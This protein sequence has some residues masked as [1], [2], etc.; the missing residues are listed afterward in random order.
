[1]SQGVGVWK[2]ILKERDLIFQNSNLEISRKKYG[3]IADVV[4]SVDN[5]VTWELDINRVLNEDELKVMNQLMQV[6]GIAP[7]LL[8][9]DDVFKC[10]LANDNVFSAKA[11]YKVLINEGETCPVSNLI[12]NKEVPSKVSFMVWAGCRNSLPTVD[13]LRR[14][15]ISLC[16]GRG[17]MAI[18]EVKGYGTDYLLQYGGYYGLKEMAGCLMMKIMRFGISLLALRKLFFSGAQR[19]MCFMDAH[20]KTLS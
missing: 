16:Y 8:E 7:M 4:S 10:S 19:I 6:V 13:V 9:S 5:R 12:W 15:G 17:D 11:C 18:I 1:M 2:K 14:R 3:A 20:L